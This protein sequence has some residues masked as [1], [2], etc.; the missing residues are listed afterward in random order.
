MKK[1]LAIAA[2]L[3]ALSSGSAVATTHSLQAASCT[4]TTT[5]TTQSRNAVK[6]DGTMGTQSRTVTV[7]DVDCPGTKRDSHTVTYGAWGP[8]H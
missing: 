2:I 1:I 3:V 5:E 8:V 4:T 7:T 6:S